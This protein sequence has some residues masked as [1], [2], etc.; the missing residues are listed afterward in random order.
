MSVDASSIKKSLSLHG[1]KFSKISFHS[2]SILYTDA[3]IQYGFN[4]N[5]VN[6]SLYLLGDFTRLSIKL[7][8]AGEEPLSSFTIDPSLT[9]KELLC[10]FKKRILLNCFFNST[11][12]RTT[13][14]KVSTK[15][16]NTG[17]NWKIRSN[18]TDPVINFTDNARIRK[19][20]VKIVNPTIALNP[21]NIKFPLFL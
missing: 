21:L 15:I 8:F 4:L 14:S 17:I 11:E 1:A 19:Y 20:K 13:R 7:V 10:A 3:I 12:N 9:S 6:P 18:V 2:S 16:M 5:V